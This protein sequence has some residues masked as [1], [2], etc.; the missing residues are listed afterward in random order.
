MSKWLVFTLLAV[1]L[2]GCAEPITEF[3]GTEVEMV[4]VSYRFRLKTADINVAQ[5]ALSHFV[6]KYPQLIEKARWQIQS[7]GNSRSKAA[8]LSQ[9]YYSELQTIGVQRNHIE[10]L[11]VDNL[12][13]FDI[14]VTAIQI[15]R[16][17]AKCHQEKVG[18]FHQG[19]F[20]C[21]TDG[22]RWNSLAYPENG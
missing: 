8:E 18:K 16:K 3:R 11:V 5:R 1:G 7:N 21:Y 17:V 4:P 10:Q 19:K 9:F 2:L 15:E 6:S 13:D 14:E 20:G 22:S 12:A